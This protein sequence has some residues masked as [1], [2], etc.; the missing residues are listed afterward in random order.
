MRTFCISLFLI[1]SSTLFA[2][3]ENVKLSTKDSYDKLWKMVEKY[4]GDDLPKSV[5]NVSD[6]IL[7]K[8]SKDYSFQNFA[9]AFLIKANAR[10]RISTDS[11]LVD[12]AQMEQLLYTPTVAKGDDSA[13]KTAIMNALLASVY[14]SIRYS[15]LVRS[16]DELRRECIEKTKFH[17]DEALKNKKQLANADAMKYKELFEV[18]Q[19]SKLYNNDVLSLILYFYDVNGYYKVNAIEPNETLTRHLEQAMEIYRELNMRDAALLIQMRIWEVQS[20]NESNSTRLNRTDHLNNLKKMFEDNVDVET[21]ADAFIKY[22]QMETFE[23]K[24]DRADLLEWANSKWKG[25]KYGKYISNLKDALYDKELSIH[26][27]GYIVAHKQFTITVNHSNVNQMNVTIRN[28]KN[29]LVF[30]K[31]LYDDSPLPQVSKSDT[32]LTSLPAQRYTVILEADGK[33]SQRDFVVTS[34]KL[35]SF[36]FPEGRTGVTV[37]NALSGIPQENCQVVFGNQKWMNGKYVTTDSVVVRTDAYGQAFIN[38]RNFSWAYAML[39]DDD[40]SNKCSLADINRYYIKDVNEDDLIYKTFTDRAI[41]KPGQ[42]L[43]VTGYLYLKNGDEY[44]VVP[45]HDAKIVV[46]DPNWQVVYSTTLKSDEF[47]MVTDSINI[48]TDRLNGN[49]SVTVGD[50]TQYFSVEEYKRPTFDISFDDM[51]GTL[52]FGDTVTVVGK[53]MTFSGVPVQGAKVV[54]NVN[55]KKSDFWTPWRYSNGNWK[56]LETQ[57]IETD[58]DGKFHVSV[59]LDG[60]MASDNDFEQIRNNRSILLYKVSAQVTDLAGETHEDETVLRVS[61]YD[62]NLRIKMDAQINREDSCE[63][64]VQVVNAQGKLVDADGIW[65]LK[66]YVKDESGNGFVNYEDT[67]FTGVF[68]ANKPICLSR[69]ENLPLGNYLI[70]VEAFDKKNHKCMDEESFVLFSKKDDPI[71]LNNDWI[72]SPKNIISD[73]EGL[74]IFYALTADNPYVYAYVFSKKKVEWRRI[75]ACNNNVKYL[76]LDFKEEFKDGLTVYLMYVKDDKVHQLSKYFTYQTPDKKLRLSWNTFRDKLLPGQQETWTL[77]V[78]DKDGNPVNAQ[79]LATMYDASLDALRS[80]A[81]NFGLHFDRFHPNVDSYSSISGSAYC[82]FALPFQSTNVYYNAR[83]FNLLYGFMSGSNYYFNKRAPRAIL[84]RNTNQM[85]TGDLNDFAVAEFAAEE[86]ID[87]LQKTVAVEN[88][89]EVTEAETEDNSSQDMI[90][91]ID[92]RSDFRE[93]AFFYPSLVTDSDGNVTISFSLPESLTEWKFMGFAHTKDLNYGL[94][95]AKAIARKEFMVQPNMPRFIRTGDD[96]TITTRII[97]QEEKAIDGIARMRLIDPANDDVICEQN[98]NFHL[99]PNKTTSVVFAYKPDDKYDMLICEIAGVADGVSDGER[100]WLPVLPDKKLV[101][102]T[103]PFYIQN[104]GTKEIDISSLFNFNSPIATNRK[105]VFDYTD[106]P[107]WNVVLAM[108]SVMNPT[109]DDAISWSAALYANSAL[110]HLANRIPKLRGLIQEWN[111]ESGDETTLQS[112]L[113]KNQQLKDIILQEAPWMMEAQCESVNKRQM[114]DMFDETL[115]NSRIKQAKDKLHDLQLSNGAWTWFKGMEPSYFTTFAVCDFMAKLYEYMKRTGNLIDDDVNKML[116]DGLEYL[117]NEELDYYNKYL[118]KHKKELLGNTSLHYIYMVASTEHES[119]R[120]VKA[121]INDYLKRMKGKAKLLTTYGKA[122]VAITLIAFGKIKD[123]IPYVK[124]LR[125][126]TITKP[127]MGRFFDGESTYYSWCDYRIPSHVAT[128]KAFFDTKDVFKDAQDYLND[129]QIWLL[130]QKQVQ[131]WNSTVNT[132]NAVDLLLTISPETSFHQEKLPVVTVGTN[133]IEFDKQTAG[134]GFVKSVVSE[135]VVKN[136]MSSSN[137]T[138]TVQKFSPGISWGSIF[139]QSLESLDNIKQNGTELTVERKYYLYTD[140]DWTPVDENYVY[141]IGDKMRIRHIISADRDMDFVQVRSQ[142]AACL[143]P[144]K[145]H[146]GYQQLG[147]RYGYLALHDSSADF[148][149]SKFLKGTA[150]ID[151]DL[152]VTSTGNYSNGIVTVQC[153]YAPEFAGHSKGSR[154]FV[155]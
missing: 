127:G 106:N 101:T 142:H 88:K 124:S 132:I 17:I 133:N 30:Q 32:I 153:A 92:I 53:V 39:N 139:G 25:T 105:M 10:M 34:Q 23:T 95:K 61:D 100:N 8:A 144:I 80:N 5:D 6:V 73:G 112:E 146:S 28:S 135:D 108:H 24:K 58:D 102:E 54:A 129:M 151:L 66:R 150:T 130:R 138:V 77:S 50:D 87:M 125:E 36:C 67:G 3:E 38:S 65:K 103:V 70:Y 84:S 59:F 82:S 90:G 60:D 22:Y 83:T 155:K 119:K 52:S 120:E 122:N 154:I 109:D 13:Q 136:T 111:K 89:Q 37:V 147:G 145:T 29:Q 63:F 49:F 55:L 45:N 21:G 40:I 76:H 78:R 131:Q 4:N 113:E 110:Q 41:Y 75:D 7:K 33:K 14:S 57:E 42:T 74:D 116:N 19:D 143:E 46:K 18:G 15:S 148:F 141:D 68:Q 97:N 114:I 117:D 134:L 43:H 56:L 107:T 79:M 64:V 16:N 35:V 152:Y 98:V 71:T 93:T 62:F 99:E 69:L 96:A 104:E 126:Y 91:Q 85:V 9:K 1:F 81:W 94:I 48:P 44:Q 118:K 51:E 20:N 121:M 140:G 128:M 123:A 72:Y 27:E 12:V 26:V 115:L 11:I 137:P 149:F 2:Q 31:T 86:S 47:G